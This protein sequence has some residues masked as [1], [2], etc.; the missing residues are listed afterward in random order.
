MNKCYIRRNKNK[1]IMHTVKQ[2]LEQMDENGRII[3]EVRTDERG[4]YTI[5]NINTNTFSIC[6]YSK[7][8]DDY[9][10]YATKESFAKRVVG[11]L[12][13]GF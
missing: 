9:R 5:F 1:E 4:W 13:R 10:F 11:L 2:V 7:E 3:L 12:K 8:G 6:F